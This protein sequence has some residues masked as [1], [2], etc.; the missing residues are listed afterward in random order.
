MGKENLTFLEF[1]QKFLGKYSAIGT[2]A[3]QINKD[4]DK[5]IFISGT[6][7]EIL[8]HLRDKNYSKDS[9]NAFYPLYK[10]YRRWK[11]NNG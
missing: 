1:S 3:K 7:D 8:V 5:E 9:I 2:L 6:K 4:K 11:K 10:Q